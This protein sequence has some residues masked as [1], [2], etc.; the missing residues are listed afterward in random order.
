MAKILKKNDHM[1]F[2]NWPLFDRRY[3]LTGQLTADNLSLIS[4]QQSQRQV[5][6][7]LCLFANSVVSGGDI[8]R[9]HLLQVHCAIT[10][11]VVV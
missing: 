11:D 4:C 7:G 6:E 8:G 9:H 10:G 1:A 3:L 2:L 5:I